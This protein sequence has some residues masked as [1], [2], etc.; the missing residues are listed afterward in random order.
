VP[1]ISR[2]GLSATLA[3]AA[4]ATALSACGSGGK[5]GSDWPLPNLDLSSTRALTSSGIDRSNVA[6]LRVAWRFRFRIR[7]VDSGAF[8]ATPVVAGAVVY[9][10]DMKSNVFALDLE[11]GAVRWQHL[12]KATNPGP[13]GLAVVGTRIYGT[14]D[15]LAFA[16]S[17][18]TGRLLWQHILVSDTER[19]VDI[20]PQVA[21]GDV[22]LSTIGE[23]PNG[24]GTLYALDAATGA[25]RWKLDTIKGKWAVPAQA[26]GGG[27][28]WTPSVAGRVVYWGIANPLPWGGT[29]T[30]PNGAIFAGPA[31][32]TDSLLVTDGATGRLRWYDQVTSHDVRDYDFALPP[33]LG[34]IGSA[35][36]VFGSGKAGIV[37]A[38]NRD[39]HRR[40]WQAEVGV[41]RNDK[42]LLPR[43]QVSVCPGLY[44]GVLTPMAYAKGKLFVPVVD[45][46]M[47]GGAYGYE[48]L[49]K[50][51][52]GR[53]GRGELVALDAATGKSLWTRRLPQP[54]FS[55]ATVADGVVF[56]ATFDGTVYALDTRNG[57][58]LWSARMPALVNACP[59]LSGRTLLVGAGVPK[60]GG[61][62]ELEAFRP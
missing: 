2:R 46:C 22:Y 24:R 48:P 39:T 47:R 32:Y 38:W 7:P 52:V 29:R 25:L 45:L 12:F 27:A 43:R 60:R 31:L 1:V 16:L 51:D 53:R 3:L 11:T 9:V 34:S 21:N 28:W 55:C 37:I 10:Q 36:V 5:A 8:T 62:L 50:V 23:P 58:T 30:H 33:I 15:S 56:T 61:V 18:K 42:G 40:I 14:T 26:G 57:A 20:A 54:D 13:D 4:S 35:P 6:R 59:A 44:G 19:Y 17:K 49:E 41:H